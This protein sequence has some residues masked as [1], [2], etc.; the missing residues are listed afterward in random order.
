VSSKHLQ[1]FEILRYFAAGEICFA[2]YAALLGYHIDQG[3]LDA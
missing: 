1:A 2:L 3:D